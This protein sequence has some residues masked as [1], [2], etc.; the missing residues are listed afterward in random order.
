MRRPLPIQLDSETR[1]SLSDRA[2][3]ESLSLSATVRLLILEADARDDL[4][5]RIIDKIDHDEMRRKAKKISRY[6]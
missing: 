3:K 6:N 4:R 5:A 2:V 1:G